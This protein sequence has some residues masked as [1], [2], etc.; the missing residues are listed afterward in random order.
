MVSMEREVSAPAAG[1]AAVVRAYRHKAGLTQRELATRA[2]LS[3]AALRDLEQGRRVRPRRGSPDGLSSALGLDPEQAADVARAMSAAWSEG[4]P[5][6][7]PCTHP[8]PHREVPRTAGP[9]APS[10]GIWLAVLGPLE[11]WRDGVQLRLGPPSRRAVLGLL[12]VNP[13]ALIR[14]DT[15]IDVM[16]GP[17]P[18]STA[19]SLVQ[20]HV[21]RL[22]KLLASRELSVAG[23]GAIASDGG[24]YRLR[25]PR[26]RLDLRV[27]KELAARAAVA[28]ARGD[29]LTACDLYAQAVELWRGDPLADVELLRDLPGVA[30]LGRQLAHV[31]LRYADVACGL[32]R[33]HQVLPRLQSLAAAEPLNEAVHARLMI[34]LAGAGQQAAAVHLYEDLRLRLDRELGVYPGKDLVQAHLR[35]LQQDIPAVAPGQTQ[36]H[37]ALSVVTEHVAPRQLPAAPR[38][39]TGRV[40]ERDVLS[41]LLR[42][43]ERADGV[44]IAALTGMAG[45]GKTALAVHWAHR[46][47]DRFPDGHLFMDLRGFS[48]AGAPAAPAEILSSFLTAL[49]VPAGQIPPC[50]AEQAALYRT[51]LAGRRMLVVLD[52]AQ[53]AEQVRPLLP[54]SPGCLVLV[55]S[56][57]RLTG[58]AAAEGARLLNLGVL[59]DADSC[60]LLARGLG[61]ERAEAEPA[62][63]R[64]LVALC[65][66]LPLALCDAAARAVTRPGL[67]LAVLTAEMRDQQQRLDALET[68]EMATS[69]REVFSWSHVKLTAPAARMFRLLGLHPGPDVTVPAAASLAGMPIGLAYLSLAELCDENLITEHAPGRYACHD[70][71]RAYA[72]EVARIYGDDRHPAAI[73]RALAR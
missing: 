73:R 41:G 40:Q 50:V 9:A 26:E 27:F 21:S 36:V 44:V 6:G 18:P 37:H 10:Q 24:A 19:A 13:G 25:L 58:L 53:N 33:H 17:A 31:L 29:H 72:A 60:I 57:N 11:A 49:G 63:V 14:R 67:P 64:E 65:G 71:L 69:I 39:F 56:R 3:V 28:E 20:A 48:P 5:R 70:L 22:R 38:H 15:L 68:G 62:A 66:R 12:A 16:W 1:F 42:P 47:G 55:T 2:G 30:E 51:L 43:V 61:P 45:V 52:N 8:G 32:G 7:V 54:G 4:D 23:G 35:V 59:P 34:A 46:I